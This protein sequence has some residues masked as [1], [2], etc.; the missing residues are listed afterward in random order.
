[1]SSEVAAPHWTPAELDTF[2]RL[3]RLTG[4]LRQMDRINGR[5]DMKNFVTK[6]GK[7]KC[8]AMFAE[9]QARGAT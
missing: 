4:S 9:L 3:V 1:M 8:D 6:H 7:E 5:I 2:N